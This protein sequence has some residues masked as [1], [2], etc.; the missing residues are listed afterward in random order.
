MR[1]AMTTI[2]VVCALVLATPG[3]V[4]AE[5]DP[6]AVRLFEEALTS[7]NA[8]EWA[9][10][11]TGF[12]QAYQLEPEAVF[13]YNAA[14]ARGALA[15]D[16]PA[17]LEA[18]L[19]LL[20]RAQAQEERPL[21]GKLE[22]SAAEYREELLAKILESERLK[23]E[24]RLAE[25]DALKGNPDNYV[26][27]G[28]LGWTGVGVIALGG[29]SFGVSGYFNNQVRVIGQELEGPDANRADYDRLA[30]NYK[31]SQQTGQLTLYVGGAIAA[32]GAGLLVWDLMTLDLIEEVPTDQ[33]TLTF[34]V[35]GAG[36]RVEV[37]F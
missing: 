14:K 25:L 27:F 12:L 8:G 26:R 17:K 21:V 30:S 19:K 4:Y 28:A 23:E 31:G 36:A 29:V 37:T 5:A 10:A 16:D 7:Y 22:A 6:E 24:R 20:E 2:G 35:T 13:L 3:T 9:Q 15:G 33:G 18:A 1:I 11:A 32:L 34:S